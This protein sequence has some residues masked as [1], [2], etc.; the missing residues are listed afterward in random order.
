MLEHPSSKGAKLNKKITAYLIGHITVK[1]AEK[2]AEYRGKVPATLAPWG[3]DLVCRGKLLSILCG[4]HIHTD[5]V[6]IRFPDA[7]AVNNWFNSLAYQAL[8]PI[9]EQAA[10]MVLVSYESAP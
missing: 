3:A 1:D 7:D 8:I 10:E 6:V 4:E 2:W 5:S 9:R